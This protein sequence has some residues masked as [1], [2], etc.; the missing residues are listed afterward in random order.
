M[1]NV[2]RSKEV[3]KHPPKSL[4]GK[5]VIIPVRGLYVTGEYRP[6]YYNENG[7][8]I[9]DIS[10]SKPKIVNFTDKISLSGDDP[11]LRVLSFDLDTSV[12]DLTIYT[13]ESASSGYDFALKV[14]TFDLDTSFPDCLFYTS[15]TVSSGV[16]FALQVL[17]FDLDATYPDIS[18]YNKTN[19]S[20]T[21]EPM[22]RITSI[23]T[24]KAIISDYNP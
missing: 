2:F 13:T 16:D 20:N 24:E 21:P 1:A 5:N 14:L 9:T 22:L 18:F 8:M 19:K 12:P 23:Q 10:G 17:D 6:P 11:V 15:E 7:I 3:Y 4:H